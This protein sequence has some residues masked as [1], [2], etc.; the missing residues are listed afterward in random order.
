MT[1]SFVKVYLANTI[2]LHLQKAHSCQTLPPA[3]SHHH[4]P[5]SENINTCIIILNDQINKS[6]VHSRRPQVGGAEAIGQFL[7]IQKKKLMLKGLIKIL[8]MDYISIHKSSGSNPINNLKSHY[9]IHKES[10]E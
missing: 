4:H 3:F 7:I 9:A 2:L 10:I 8:R 5:H 1:G 6:S